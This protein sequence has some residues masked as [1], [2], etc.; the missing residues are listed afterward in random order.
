[1]LHLSNLFGIGIAFELNLAVANF[2]NRSIQG[3]FLGRDQRL[4]YFDSKGGSL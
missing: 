2:P 3:L 4:E 1:M